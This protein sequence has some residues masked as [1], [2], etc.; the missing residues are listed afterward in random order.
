MA[1]PKYAFPES[2]VEELVGA[3]DGTAR[4]LYRSLDL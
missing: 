4:E 3:Q 2:L 1:L